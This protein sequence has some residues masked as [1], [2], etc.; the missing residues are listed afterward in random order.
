MKNSLDTI[1]GVGEKAIEALKRLN[2]YSPNDLLFHFPSNV[3]NKK[4]YQPIFSL[5][6]GD[7]VVLKVKIIAI[8][9]PSSSY[10][11]KRRAFRI[12]CENETGKLQLLYF[13]YYP[14]YLL[15]WAKVGSEVL[16]IGKI[17][18]FNSIK[19]IAH[20]EVLNCDNLHNK[21]DESEVI[22]PLTYALLNK[23]LRKYIHFT[24]EQQQIP[25]E[26][27]SSDLIIKYN[28]KSFLECLKNI[29]QPKNNKEIDLYSNERQRIAYDEL[30][31]TQL[32]VNLLR[33]YKNKQ[34]GRAIISSGKL[35]KE[36]INNL[37]FELT[38]EQQ[39]AIED[40]IKDQNSNNKMSRLL[41]GDVGSG[42]TVVAIAAILNAVESNS[43]AVLMAPTDVLANQ[44]NL[45][46]E[47][48]LF[49]LPIKFALLTGKTKPK[50][51]AKIMEDLAN[52]KIQILIGTHAVFQDKVEF[53]DLALVVID[54]QHRFG[55]EQRL[56]L[57]NKGNNPDLLIMS[58]TPIPRSLSLVLYGDMDVTRISEKPKSRIPIKTSIMPTSK[59]NSVVDSL[60]NILESRGKIYWIC[61]LVSEPDEPEPE[62]T[63]VAAETRM[64][65]LANIY[66]NIVGLVHGKLDNKLKQDNLMKFANGDFKILVAT[67][68][69]EVGVD[70]PDAT[71]III[72]NAESFGLSQLHQLR[73]RVGRGDKASH[74]I[75]LYKS[76]IS[77][78]SWQRL[79]IIKDTED[80]FVL[81]EEDLKLRGG[82]DLSGTKQSGVPDFKSVDFV[83]HHHLISAAHKQAKDILTK[84]STLS[85]DESKKYHD[86]LKIFGFNYKSLDW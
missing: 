78:T 4:I 2:I 59:L 35:Y 77:N 69:V 34:L 21:V 43:Q 28:W 62:N 56:S 61:P 80:G 79:K 52:G 85:L 38:N 73:G 13:S 53:K 51:R 37:P 36:F 71:V 42:K 45:T 25:N 20:P 6:I 5:N 17:D 14:N 54:E 24:L 15:K 83:A 74:C 57:V 70:V 8:D 9:Q 72:E 67:T 3:I 41:Q 23:Q 32:M 64:K 40:I 84:D 75:L 44:H 65:S 1:P 66:P 76:P 16:T 26:W 48:F 22:Y 11:S 55:V 29:H 10:S 49:N 68:V 31:A 47:K 82:G 46:L 30:L 60:K 33:H 19:Q 7:L 81:A 50:I 18:V 86:L 63:K 12:Y 27:I 58:A 39:K